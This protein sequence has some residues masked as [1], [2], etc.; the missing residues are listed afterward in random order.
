[1]RQ[2]IAIPAVFVVFVILLVSGLY[3]HQRHLMGSLRCPSGFTLEWDRNMGA[4]CI[5]K[6]VPKL[7]G[8]MGK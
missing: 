8:D 2:L 3:W 5:V 7:F 4:I 6:P 1:M